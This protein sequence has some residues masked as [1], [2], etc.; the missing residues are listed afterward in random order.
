MSDIDVD[1]KNLFKKIGGE[2]PTYQELRRQSRTEQARERWPLLHSLQV[3][4]GTAPDASGISAPSKSEKTSGARSKKSG[5]SKL[6]KSLEGGKASLEVPV[7]PR[8][9]AKDPLSGLFARQKEVEP[10]VPETQAFFHKRPQPEV[11]PAAIK[12]AEK[13]PLSG[14]FSR[15]KETPIEAAATNL[16]RKRRE[17][18]APVQGQNLFNRL[19]EQQENSPTYWQSIFD[20]LKKP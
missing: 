16:F 10:V 12:P 15:Q 5:L 13:G 6:F 19:F 18:D 2:E 4:E 11:Q 17:V 14:L 20:K 3:G 7:A 9:A 1:V 8:P